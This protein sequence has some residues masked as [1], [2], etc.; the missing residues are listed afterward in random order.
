V[1]GN[2]FHNALKFSPDGG[3]VEVRTAD[4]EDRLTISVSDHGVGMDR[5]L[6]AQLFAPAWAGRTAPRS[7]AGLGLGLI[8]TKA[9]LDAHAG[10]VSAA[11]EGL[12]KGSTFTV[13]LPLAPGSEVSLPPLARKTRLSAVIG[14]SSEQI[15]GSK[16]R[17]G[18]RP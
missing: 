6:K 7:A 13:E 18:Q 5:I 8:I 14:T 15:H 3:H 16:G 2:L 1:F 9:I 12:G 4:D 10:R 17:S 11:S